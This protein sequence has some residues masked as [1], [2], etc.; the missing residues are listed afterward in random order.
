MSLLQFGVPRRLPL[1]GRVPQSEGQESI[2]AA[3]HARRECPR[4]AQ[5][6][7]KH[8]NRQQAPERD[9]HADAVV[10]PNLRIDE[11]VEQPA[12]AA[13]RPEDRRP[14][15]SAR[16]VR[17][18]ASDLPRAFRRRP[19]RITNPS[20]PTNAEHAIPVLVDVD[21]FGVVDLGHVPDAPD[22][23]CRRTARPA[24]SPSGSRHP[25]RS[26]AVGRPP[27]SLR[28]RARPGRRAGHTQTRTPRPRWRVAN[29]APAGRHEPS[30]NPRYSPAT[31]RKKQPKNA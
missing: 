30:L 18:A 12:E 1:R 7:I 13:A 15:R 14:R 8:A 23:V 10:A 20:A 9:E 22:P 21:A 31:T 3:S 6:S 29:P 2:A 28:V 16:R 17:R 4:A 26:R 19:S 24:R 25:P 27:G 5:R 11:E